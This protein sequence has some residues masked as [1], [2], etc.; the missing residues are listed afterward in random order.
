M[1]GGGGGM[2]GNV[3]GSFD[4][5]F[6]RPDSFHHQE[7]FSLSNVSVKQSDNQTDRSSAVQSLHSKMDLSLSTG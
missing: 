7:C 1:N 3:C 6:V 2:R 4:R 5:L